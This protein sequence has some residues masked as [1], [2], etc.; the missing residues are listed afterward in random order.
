MFVRTASYF[1]K[2][3]DKRRQV[4]EARSSCT[5]IPSKKTGQKKKSRRGTFIKKCFIT[6]H[7]KRQSTKE[8]KSMR[9]VHEMLHNGT[10][11][12]KCQRKKTSRRGTSMQC[13]I[14]GVQEKK[15]RRN[16][17]H[18]NLHHTG[19]TAGE[20]KRFY[21]YRFPNSSSMHRT[22]TAVVAVVSS[23]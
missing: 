7:V 16:V 14:T 2:R 8:D 12:R 6:G 9:H 3:L 20:S 21:G 18:F 15:S 22:S 23:W 5:I 13:F 11:R 17:H 4:D 19:S 1:S 10:C